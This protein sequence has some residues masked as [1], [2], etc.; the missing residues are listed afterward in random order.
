MKNKY[1]PDEE[2]TQNDLFFLCSMIERVA[3][4]LHRRNNY[5]VNAIGKDQLLHL[6]SVAGVLHCENPEQVAQD[7]IDDYH[8][9]PGQFDITDVDPKLCEKIPS[10]TAIGKVYT[11][12]ITDTLK[13]NE[14]FASAVIRV[15]NDPICRVIDNYNAS[16]YFEPSYVVAKAY[17]D[18][19][20]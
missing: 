19:G 20:F 14:D 18:G 16:A 6:L 10:A 5:V 7:W 17:F 8:L 4:T 2:I 9:T 1:F 15:Y 13:P 11:R 3:R 12:L